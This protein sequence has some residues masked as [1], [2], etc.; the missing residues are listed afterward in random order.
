MSYVLPP[1]TKEQE[2]IIQK[3]ENNNL[4]I[5]AVAGSGKTTTSLYIAKNFQN[6]K[7]LLLTYNSK[8]KAETRKKVFSLGIKNLEVHSFHA[9]GYKYY[10]EKKCTTDRGI[11]EIIN[12]KTK[13]ALAFKFDLIIIDEAQDITPLYYE[14]ICKIIVDNGLSAR[15]CLLGDKNQSIYS[16]NNADSRY[17][18]LAD[19]FFSFNERP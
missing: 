3:L 10:N 19:H 2:E 15:I 6:L 9:F 16:F 14:F 17:L 18:S 12:Q 7:I 4:I 11:H 13:P 8:L 5:E 1:K